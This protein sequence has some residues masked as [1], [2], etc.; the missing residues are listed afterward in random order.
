M[1][2]PSGFRDP[3][4]FP[5][6][7]RLEARAPAILE[8]LR[9]L[10]AGDS[11]FSPWPERELYATGWTVFG[12]YFF[13]RE[14]DGNCARCPRTA[15]AVRDVPGLTTAGFS[16]MAPGTHIRP[17]VGFTSAVLRCHLGLVVRDGCAIRVGGETRSWE[18]GKCLIFDDTLEHE[19]WNRSDGD[20][21]VLLLDFVRDAAP[22]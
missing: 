1:A 17:H 7:A 5:F 2:G 10:P 20:R 21:I 12:F 8:E 9:A 16:R 3:A 22:R 4:A 11:E 14:I 18:A 15:A 19:A 6:A 13:G